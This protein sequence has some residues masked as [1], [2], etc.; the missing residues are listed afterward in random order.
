MSNFTPPDNETMKKLRPVSKKVEEYQSGSAHH[1]YP[2]EAFPADAPLTRLL[3]V[4]LNDHD[5][6]KL[7]FLRDTEKRLVSAI[8]RRLFIDALNKEVDKTIKEL[9]K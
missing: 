8:T 1:Q 3:N 2:W 4:K 6:A 7:H 5:F 9:N